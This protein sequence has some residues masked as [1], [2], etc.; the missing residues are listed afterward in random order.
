MSSSRQER[1]APLTGVVFAVIFYVAISLT[2][3]EPLLTGR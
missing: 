1:L 2:G 3:G